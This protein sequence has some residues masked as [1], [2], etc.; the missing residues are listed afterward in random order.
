VEVAPKPSTSPWA[1]GVV[2]RVWR[3]KSWALARE[4]VSSSLR[5]HK[6][7]GA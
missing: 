5:A 4:P 7:G 2:E 3:D 1:D 6:A